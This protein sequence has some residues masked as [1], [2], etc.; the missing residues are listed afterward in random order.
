M[1]IVRLGMT[2]AMLSPMLVDIGW[3]LEDVGFTLNVAGSLVGLMAVFCACL[4]IRRFGRRR[5]L[6]AAAFVQ[7]AIIL[8]V[9]PLGGGVNAT[10]FILPGLVLVF[11]IY[12]PIATVML[13]IMMNRA[14]AG[15]EG[16]DFTAQHSLYSLSSPRRARRRRRRPRTP[17]REGCRR[18]APARP[19]R[20]TL[21]PQ[22]LRAMRH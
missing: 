21:P 16:T 15:S 20:R 6:V 9:L 19:S 1:M 8:S 4:L 2:F 17:T 10:A 22:G 18:R 7:A 12:N 14:T 3:P 11:L 13:T 5:M